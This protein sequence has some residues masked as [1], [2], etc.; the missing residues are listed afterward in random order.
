MAQETGVMSMVVTALRRLEDS[1][2]RLAGD[3]NSQL[4]RLPE[5]YVPRREVERRFDELHI[6]LGA[7][8]AAR[9]A[10][11]ADAGTKVTDLERRLVEG[12]RWFV[13]LACGTGLTT[14]GLLVNVVDRLQ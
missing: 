10:A 11:V 9:Q 2:S 13:G 14:V 8:Q 12:R 6:D 7:E 4:S 1:V 3:M 5:Q